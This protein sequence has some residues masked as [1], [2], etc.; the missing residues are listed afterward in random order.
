MNSSTCHACTLHAQVNAR[1]QAAAVGM[2]EGVN[3]VT[4]LLV[5]PFILVG[6]FHSFLLFFVRSPFLVA[7]SHCVALP[8]GYGL[9]YCSAVQLACRLPRGQLVPEGESGP[10][11]EEAPRIQS[12]PFDEVSLQHAP[13]NSLTVV[14]P[15]VCATHCYSV[16]LTCT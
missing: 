14:H 15:Q 10:G 9:M 11:K 7:S 13:A 3:A 6:M 12:S 1:K 4:L 8:V 2:E 16:H 5:G